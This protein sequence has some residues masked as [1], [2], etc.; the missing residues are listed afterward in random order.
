V[1]KL[2]HKIIPG[3]YV[4]H[5]YDYLFPDAPIGVVVAINSKTVTIVW[6]GKRLGI[7]DELCSDLRNV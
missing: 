3:D 2:T 6:G 4:M 5:I 1:N 7:K